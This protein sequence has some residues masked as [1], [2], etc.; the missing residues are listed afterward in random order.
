VIDPKNL[1]GKPLVVYI[2]GERHQIGTITRGVIES[3]N[4]YV[5]ATLELEQND[6]A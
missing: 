4:I 2:D 5:A 6:D 1:I 3:G